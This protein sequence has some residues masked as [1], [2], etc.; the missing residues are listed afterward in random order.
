MPGHERD[1]FFETVRSLPKLRREA[2]AL[3]AEHDRATAQRQEA[4]GRV[5]KAQSK[6]QAAGTPQA[7]SGATRALAK[8]NRDA[9]EAMRRIESATV[10][11]QAKAKERIG[12]QA[13][14]DALRARRWPRPDPAEMTALAALLDEETQRLRTLALSDPPTVLA[15]LLDERDF[16]LSVVSEAWRIVLEPHPGS[17]R[18]TW[19]HELL[20]M[21]RG[22]RLKAKGRSHSQA[23]RRKARPSGGLTAEEWVALKRRYGSRCVSCG[24]TEPDVQLT[25]DHV[26]PLALG[27]EDRPE[28]IQPLCITCNMW[29]GLSHIDFRRTNR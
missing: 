21:E 12:A 10:R 6:L 8:A 7:R 19:M 25:Q 15:K 4:L 18:S 20:A 29:K 16:L 17:H 5:E 9:E 27:G 2:R 13:D 3:L 1:V 11:L 22:Q 28:N 26:L 23:F 14:V 24:R